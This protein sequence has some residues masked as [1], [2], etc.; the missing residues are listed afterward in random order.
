MLAARREHGVFLVSDAVATPK[1]AGG[2]GPGLG[3]E[4]SS[5]GGQ[6]ELSAD[7]ALRHR[8]PGFLAGSVQA[9]DVGVATAAR[10]TGSLAGAV[11]FASTAPAA[12]V[13]L[14]NPWHPGAR[15]DLVEFDWQPGDREL[16]PR[17]VYVAGEPAA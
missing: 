5:V 7:G 4:V 1:A 11:A 12:A 13:G 17:R 6:V 16:A 15:A 3:G 2:A 9:L 8:E 14:A 10:V